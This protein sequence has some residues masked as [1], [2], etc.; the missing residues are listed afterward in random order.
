MR[1]ILVYANDLVLFA[2]L[3]LLRSTRNSIVR[4]RRRRRWLCLIP[5]AGHEEFYFVEGTVEE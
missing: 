3:G 5:D 1:L 2:G 4:R